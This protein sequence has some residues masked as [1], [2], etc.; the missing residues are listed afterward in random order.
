VLLLILRH[1]DAIIDLL[2]IDRTGQCSRQ[3][4]SADAGGPRKMK[5]R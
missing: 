3:L 1:V 5:L 2:V 4:V